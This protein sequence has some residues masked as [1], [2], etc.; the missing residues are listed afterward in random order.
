MSKIQ[1]TL[2]ALQPYVIGIRYLEGSPLVDVVFKEGWTVLEDSKIKRVKG[3]EEMNYYMIFSEM[4]GVD[5]DDLLTYVDKTIK[6]NLE[7]EKKHELLKVKVNEL[8]EIFKKNSLTKLNRL[9]FVFGDE[10][11]VPNITDI[12]I[13]LDT[14]PKQ[15]IENKIIAPVDEIKI[16]PKQEITPKTFLDEHGNP[17]QLSE[18][19]LEILE[20]EERAERNRKIIE[21]KRLNETKKPQKRVELPPKRKPEM[22]THDSDYDSDCEC[23]PDEA[24][25]K[26]ID[27]K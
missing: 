21:N 1:K 8:K 11:L 10:E 20:E 24:C 9:Q 19:D 7:R 22:V 13:D 12:D 3:N 17:I 2:D 5:I 16:E 25:S 18:E 15:D 23:G 27:K 14:E 6:F 4:S 26:C